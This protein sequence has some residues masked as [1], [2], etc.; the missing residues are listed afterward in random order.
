MHDLG[1]RDYLHILQRRKWIVLL[2]V[3]I[4]PLAAVAFSLRQ[5]PLYQ[6]SS[7]VLLRD[8]TLPTGVGGNNGTSS[9]SSNPA[10]TIGTQLLI[11]ERALAPRV[12]GAL[13]LSPGAVAGSTDVAQIGDT[14]VLQFTSR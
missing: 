9:Y 5:S 10:A 12:A 14:N 6:A 7:T 8:Q 2:A 3:V 4:V 13:H 1:L 11:A